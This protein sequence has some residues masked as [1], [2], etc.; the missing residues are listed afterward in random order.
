M[1]KA[2]EVLR[3][4]IA[5]KQDVIDA[6][7][8]IQ[9][10]QGEQVT[11][12]GRS[13]ICVVDK[14]EDLGVGLRLFTKNGGVHDY[15]KGLA[16]D[17]LPKLVDRALA[18]TK[19]NQR[20]YL[21]PLWLPE[22]DSGDLQADFCDDT[23]SLITLDE[24]ISKVNRLQ[25]YVNTY[26]KNQLA[27]KTAIYRE[28]H[29]AE[30]LWNSRSDQLL[31][32]SKTSGMVSTQV[33]AEGV[34]EESF[35]ESQSREIRYHT[36]NWHEVATQSC[37]MA[38][39]LQKPKLLEKRQRRAVIIHKAAM[40]PLFEILAHHLKGSTHLEGNSFLKNKVGK[41][42]FSKT[43]S[44]IE[45]P[46]LANSV[47]QCFWDQEGIATRP[48]MYVNQGVLHHFANDIKTAMT[49]DRAPSGNGIRRHYQD[50][51]SVG[52]H[53]LFWEPGKKD[54]VD[55]LRD[56]GI[57]FVVRKILSMKLTDSN[58]G[59]LQMRVI[60]AEVSGG[61]EK[62]AKVAQ[63]DCNLLDMLSC[64][65][66]CSRDLQ[67]AGPYGVPSVLFKKLELNKVE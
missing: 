48:R 57:G 26:T 60:G 41:R 45:D 29:L 47:G 6:E 15:C 37:E 46:H 12:K 40:V 44:I 51:P 32:S 25:E 16:T 8:Y 22:L 27:V 24:K 36:L 35:G 53:M 2:V 54:F 5:G 64:V 21:T 39:R 43:V 7:I 1:T 33:S 19:N 17:E 10:I 30:W 59:Q 65:E 49:L 28:E 55:L 31:E 67:W 62:E 63:M 61:E 42:I 52:F 56:A 20:N 23:Y 4:H 66:S 38:L 18:R 34:I 50:S 9:S 3:L 58:S 13:S 14:M 11:A